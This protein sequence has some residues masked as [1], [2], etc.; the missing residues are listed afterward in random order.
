MRIFFTPLLRTVFAVVASIALGTGLG[1]VNVSK[2][3]CGYIGDDGYGPQ[4]CFNRSDCQCDEYG[5]DLPGPPYYVCDVWD[6]G[7]E[8][9]ECVPDIFFYTVRYGTAI[10]SSCSIDPCTCPPSQ[11]WE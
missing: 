5:C 4:G 1:F 9:A 6:C 8:S 3:A 7:R 2:A 11:C 10:T